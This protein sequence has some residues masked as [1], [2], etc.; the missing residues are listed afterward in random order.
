MDLI[1]HNYSSASTKLR[2]AVA[3]DSS[4]ACSTLA[5]LLYKGISTEEESTSMSPPSPPVV[6]SQKGNSSRFSIGGSR[7]LPDLKRDRQEAARLFVR[8]LEIELAKPLKGSES[9]T[10][11]VNLSRKS[12]RDNRE[13]MYG[14]ASEE[15]GAEGDFFNLERALDLVVGV[16]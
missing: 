4:A 14:S 10:S 9:P 11:K 7:T 16:S 5:R 2:K 15:E 1:G 12:S 13:G 6:S 3:L 8:G